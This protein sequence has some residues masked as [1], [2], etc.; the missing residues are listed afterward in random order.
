[1]FSEFPKEADGLV[2]NNRTPDSHWGKPETVE[3]MLRIG[4]LWKERFPNSAISIGQ[5]SR[6]NGGPMPPHK[7]H[8]LGVDV[9]IRP[10]R[11]DL[12]NL[13]VTFQDKAN[14]NR[15]L[16]WELIRMVRANAKVKL[17][18][19]NDPRLIAEGL[20]QPFAGHDNHLHFRFLY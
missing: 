1:M 7:S 4:R 19:F 20:C 18:L 3:A 17:V 5:V 2:F 12:K 6:K 16:T 13:P 10:M 14:Y 15:D 11:N 9:D 8:R